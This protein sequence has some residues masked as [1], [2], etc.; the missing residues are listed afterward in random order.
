MN[1]YNYIRNELEDEYGILGLQ[2]KI[3][4]IMVYLDLFC[5][6]H[7]IKYFL[8][9]GS[10]LGAMRH[11]GF[12]PWDD[13]L[14]VF[15]DY[16]NYEKFFDLCKT[17]LDNSKYVLQ[18]QNTDEMPYYFSK[19]RMKG[20]SCIGSVS[21]KNKKLHPHN[22]IFVDIMCLHN[23]AK[24]KTGKKIQ[25]Y[26]A[27]LLKA[28]AITKTTYKAKGFKK[29]MQLFIAKCIVWGPIKRLLYHLV[30]KYDKKPSL[31]YAHL[32]GRAKYDNSFYPKKLF[33]EQRYVP[34]EKVKLAVPNGVEEYLIL[35]YGNNYMEMP[36]EKTKSI[37]Q[38]HATIWDTEKEIEQ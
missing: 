19:L 35:R 9:G 3:L 10:A 27:G 20:T 26:A 22:G 17:E 13:D 37:Y 25:Y 16:E 36:D 12:I 11:N 21:L 31:E 1:N 34:F 15:M 24:T 32:F 14:D 2:N 18:K 33:H 6:Q 5:R 4:E 7:E 29:K 23:A 8:M 28:K 38:S 30:V